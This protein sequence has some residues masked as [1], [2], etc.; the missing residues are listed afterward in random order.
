MR[1]LH[2]IWVWEAF[3]SL[4]FLELVKTVSSN[5]FLI[6]KTMICEYQVLS[7]HANIIA[8]SLA[9]YLIT[10]SYRNLHVYIA[11]ECETKVLSMLLEMLLLVDAGVL[12]SI[13]FY[14]L[15]NTFTV[16]IL[17]NFVI[18]TCLFLFLSNHIPLYNTRIIHALKNVTAHW[19]WIPQTMARTTLV[20]LAAQA[21]YKATSIDEF[22]CLTKRKI[23]S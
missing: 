4:K 11:F 16:Q 9:R 21:W 17:Y 22:I 20:M 12:S 19:L 8:I 1:K 3:I 14:C 15:E 23:I 13:T 7:I 18:S 10:S 6:C 5:T 2:F